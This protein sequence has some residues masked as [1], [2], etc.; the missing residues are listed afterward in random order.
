M[1]P[2]A[3]AYQRPASIEEAL[4][5]IGADPGAKLLAGGQSLLPL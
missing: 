5:I 3:F 4:K 1:I 2:A